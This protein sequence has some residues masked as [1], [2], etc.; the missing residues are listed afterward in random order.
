MVFDYNFIAKNPTVIIFS[1]AAFLF[2]FGSLS[3]DQDF[4]NDG[5]QIFAWG[6]VLQFIWMV[7]FKRGRNL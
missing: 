1:I 2:I 3:N 6:M 5:L 4:I 7:V